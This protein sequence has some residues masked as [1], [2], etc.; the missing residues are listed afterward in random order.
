MTNENSDTPEPVENAE[1]KKPKRTLTELVVVIAVLAMLAGLLLPALNSAREKGQRTTCLSN[2]KQIGL[3][4][5]LYSGDH[6]ERFPTAGSPPNPVESFG[7]LINTGK[8]QQPSK[9]EPH[10]WMW[11]CQS[12]RG[13]TIGS[14]TSAW[15]SANLS[16]A[17]GGFGLTE[18]VQP[19][20]PL[21]CDRTS[22]D[23]TSATPYV[24]NKWTH[25][26]DGGNVLY[27]DGHAD[28]QMTFT[29]PMYHGRNP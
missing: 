13:T 16:Y 4:L 27:A 18:N 6:D 25:K 8:V 1:S 23:V 17:Y 26:S 20:T 15:T 3:S 14:K 29:P 12:D 22:G 21:A 5:R 19:D 24:N 11:V 2:L 7:L 10:S 28:F 9:V